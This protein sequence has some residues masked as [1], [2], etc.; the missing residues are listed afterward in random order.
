M[1]AV[2][3]VNPD[4]RWRSYTAA[5][6]QTVFAI[7]FPFQDADDIIILK[8]ALDGAVTTLALPADYTVA[9]VNNPAGGSFTLTAPA[10]AGEKFMPIGKAVLERV[11]SIV[12]GG[13]YNSAATDEDL[14]RLMI[15][16]QENRRDID[17]SWKAAFGIAGGQITA[18]AD[19]ELVKFEDGNIVGS[20]ENVDTIEG[21]TAA[22]A[23]SAVEAAAQAGIATAQAGV[24]TTKANEA[25]A[26]A[27]IASPKE[28]ATIAEAAAYALPTVPVFVR[29]AGYGAGGDGGGGL[30]KVVGA[31]PAEKGSFAMPAIGKWAKL[32]ENGAHVR[33]FGAHPNLADNTAKINDAMLYA[34]SRGENMHIPAGVYVCDGQ[35]LLKAR[36]VTGDGQ[37]LSRIVSTLGGQSAVMIA[38]QTAVADDNAYRVWRDFAVA[39][40]AANGGTYGI[41]VALNNA[42][43]FL[44]NWVMER[45]YVG[46][47]G[48]DGIRLNNS[49]GNTNGIFRGTI[50]D[51]WIQ[52]GLL[53]EKGGDS[54]SILRNTIHGTGIGVYATMIGGARQLVLR[55]NNI[56][57][58]AEC[59]Y[60]SGIN[61]DA[62]IIENWME[63]PN[64]L[65]NYSGLSGAILYL[66][67]SSGAVIKRNTIQ[68]L[69]AA[70]GG[71]VPA[72]T[73]I[74]AA[75]N[76]DDTII[77]ENT[78]Y[79]GAVSHIQ[80]ALAAN[81]TFI[82]P[83]NKYDSAL[84]VTDNATDTIGKLSV[85]HVFDAGLLP[86][87]N[88]GG[89]LGS[90][91]KAW[92]DVFLA[93]G[94][95]I[96][97]AAGDVTIT[98]SADA[99][100]FAG[101]AN[102]YS[103]DNVIK[104]GGNQVL[105][106]RET[107]WTAGTG[108]AL[109]GAFASYAG[110]AHTGAY[111]QATIQALDNAARDAS[112]RVKAIEDALRNHGLIN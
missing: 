103:F 26:S 33:L 29:T 47:F 10:A 91:A 8:V 82:G 7:P 109:K 90:A 86:V 104:I 6:A 85:G 18:G 4:A 12:R 89:A 28:F 57:H 24:A 99:L 19:G 48:G 108:T 101:A 41:E 21:A 45:L 55:N 93:S 22:A 69:T 87:A 11:L 14:D 13:R 111:V 36:S 15:I 81:R 71:F 54:L 94:G 110:Q 52:N 77:D 2:F 35:V 100:A 49:I 32:T 43:E 51:S 20:G 78:I 68:P 25:A 42:G 5:A 79:K 53:I 17:R 44:S 105:K 39:P 46:P 96:N 74:F 65:G 56:T 70:G 66:E 88:D 9:G 16:A 107:G 75:G 34:E 83:R 31:D 58:L 67:N 106:A 40:S 1:S 98:H 84:T 62:H 80:T 64:Y 23:A 38:P 95:V 112:Q 63:T 59:I 102:G 50:Q 61:G 92:S 27:A 30:Y 97:Y 72:N 3:P 73:G 37:Y 60:L 76:S